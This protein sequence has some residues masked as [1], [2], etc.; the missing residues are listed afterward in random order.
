M[1]AGI[2]CAGNWIV[3]VV[4]DIER[5][6]SEGDLVRISAQ[7]MGVGGGAANVCSDLIS[8]GAGFPV[9]ALGCIGDDEHAEVVLEHL[10]RLN[11]ADSGLHRLPQTATAHT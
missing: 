4:H 10:R 9:A 11:I 6:P 1:K 7:S 5:W 8:L 3:D 2:A